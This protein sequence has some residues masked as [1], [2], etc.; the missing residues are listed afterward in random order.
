MPTVIYVDGNAV[1]TFDWLAAPSIGSL[2]VGAGNPAGSAQNFA[3]VISEVRSLARPSRQKIREYMSSRF[4]QRGRIEWLLA[5]G[6]RGRFRRRD[7]SP[8]GRTGTINGGTWTPGAA[9]PRIHGEF[10][11]TELASVTNLDARDRGIT[12]LAGI[13]HLSNLLSLDLSNNQLDNADLVSLVP[14]D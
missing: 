6:R 2:V 10:H 12:N 3:G 1:L 4:R 11:A 5:V 7:R 9:Y 13:E 8:F 14:A